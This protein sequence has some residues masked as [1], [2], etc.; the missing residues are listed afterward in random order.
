[1]IQI[2]HPNSRTH[3]CGFFIQ[4][5]TPNQTECGLGAFSFTQNALN[6]GA[7]RLVCA[8]DTSDPA[9]RSALPLFELYAHPLH[10]LSSRLFL[11]HGGGPADPFIARERS[12][13]L[14]HCECR[15][16][17]SKCFL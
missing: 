12:Q 14:P 11:F 9:T 17:G 2:F 3:R 6:R 5:K 7:D 16:V 13:T 1:M 8:M 15:R 4:E 10:M